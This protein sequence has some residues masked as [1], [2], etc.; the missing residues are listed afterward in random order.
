MAY[1]DNQRAFHR[2]SAA[3][4]RA[5][6]QEQRK[7]MQASNYGGLSFDQMEHFSAGFVDGMAFITT[8]DCKNALQDSINFFFK[9]LSYRDISN[10]SNMVKFP[11]YLTQFQEAYGSVYT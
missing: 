9:A 7:V 10:F 6:I 2:D 4:Y 11:L 5:R 1:W 3:A 8:D